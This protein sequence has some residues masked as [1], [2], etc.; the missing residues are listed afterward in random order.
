LKTEQENQDIVIKEQLEDDIIQKGFEK[1]ESK[2]SK[3]YVKWK[4]YRPLVLNKWWKFMLLVS[5]LL[6]LLL[7]VL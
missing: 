6:W 7:V 1:L 5:V 2:K 3:T 4:L